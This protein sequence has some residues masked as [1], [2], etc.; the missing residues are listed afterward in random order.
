M[1]THA[2]R[3][4]L[5]YSPSQLYDLVADP[6]E[7]DNLIGTGRPEEER[8]A[9]WLARKYQWMVEHPLTGSLDEVQIESEYVEELKALG[10]LN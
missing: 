7:L 3:R 5:D 2:E 8:L 6:L 10:Y 9:G 4:V 1:P